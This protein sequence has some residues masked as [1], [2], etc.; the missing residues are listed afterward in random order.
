MWS[1]LVMR[2]KEVNDVQSLQPTTDI[3]FTLPP[4]LPAHK[5]SLLP[6]PPPHHHH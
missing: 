2:S 4:T 3:F 1:R 6:P 5:N